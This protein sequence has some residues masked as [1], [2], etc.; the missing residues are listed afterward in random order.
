M[1]DKISDAASL[2]LTLLVAYILH[3]PDGFIQSCIAVQATAEVFS[4]SI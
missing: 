4:H 2:M 1:G 3:L